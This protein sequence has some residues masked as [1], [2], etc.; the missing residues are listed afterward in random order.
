MNY[1]RDWYNYYCSLELS[2]TDP[3]SPTKQNDYIYDRIAPKNNDYNAD[4]VGLSPSPQEVLNYSYYPNQN[5]GVHGESGTTL[6]SPANK[7]PP[8]E[9]TIQERSWK[10]AHK[11]YSANDLGGPDSPKNPILGYPKPPTN[12][13]SIRCIEDT[14]IKEK[15]LQ[16]S[17]E[18]PSGFQP[19]VNNIP[20]T[21]L[22]RTGTP[23]FEEIPEPN[24]DHYLNYSKSASYEKTENISNNRNLYQASQMP[25]DNAQKYPYYY[26]TNQNAYAY[27]NSNPGYQM[28]NYQVG[29]PNDPYS[30][31]NYHAYYPDYFNQG[32]N[33]H[34]Y[35][36]QY[37]GQG[38]QTEIAHTPMNP[39]ANDN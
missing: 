28:Y 15:P 37:Y 3:R 20:G 18:K 8:K 33:G 16:R 24:I 27:E 25:N 2:H 13:P 19:F 35:D 30:H 12:S 9:Q 4:A 39:A 32:Y 21:N 1:H 31:G 23:Q 17:L 11:R 10:V 5:T 22:V 36:N 34:Y 29:N 7:F 14:G 6:K 26:S 38:Y